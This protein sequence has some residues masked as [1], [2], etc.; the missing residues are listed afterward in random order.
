MAEITQTPGFSTLGPFASSFE[1]SGNQDVTIHASVRGIV[2][3]SPVEIN[4]KWIPLRSVYARYF[5]SGE[6]KA[7]VTGLS[8]GLTVSLRSRNWSRLVLA[9]GEPRYS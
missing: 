9:R 5:P 8:A 3:V 2:R 7:L 6:I 4:F 1:P